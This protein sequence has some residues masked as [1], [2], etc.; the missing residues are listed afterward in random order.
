VSKTA[1]VV[2]LGCKA[3]QFESAALEQLLVKDGYELCS[4]EQGA[5]LVV[6]NTCTVTATTDAQSRKLVRRARRF[7]PECR[8][9]VTGCYAQID[10][11]SLVNYPGVDLVFGNMEKQSFLELLHNQEAGADKVHVGD[12]SKSSTCPKLQIASFAEH[13]RAFVQIQSGCDAFCSYCIIPFA[14]GRSRSVTVADVVKQIDHLVANGYQEVVLTG[15][16][17]GNYGRDLSTVTSL[18]AL[19]NTILDQTALHRLRLG[20][21]EPQE[22]SAELIDVVAANKRV[23][24][25]LHIPLQSGSDTVLQRMNR[26]YTTE[27]F[28]LL[29]SRL[30][31]KIE[32]ISIGIDL[33]S[34]FPGETDSEHKATVELVN[35][36]PLHY[37]HVFPYSKRTGTAAA[38]MPNHVAP[39]IIK[40]RAAQLRQLGVGKISHYRGGLVGKQIEVVVE[41]KHHGNLWKG[42]SAEYVP[43]EF[44]SPAEVGGQCFNVEVV[45][46]NDAVVVAKIGK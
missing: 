18:A 23:C 5:Q 35:Q 39:N 6:V 12:I 13:S 32:N 19:V 44:Y 8:I 7:N 21:I 34:G 45:A 1:C 30:Q 16:H 11:S 43:V 17:I 29:L 28:K 37:L 25:H 4:F 10:P 24:P 38:T 14:R 42:V 26:H 3:N 31:N 9:A 41:K 22:L 36:L 46:V 40:V 20:S 2:T 27:Q 15:I 33:I